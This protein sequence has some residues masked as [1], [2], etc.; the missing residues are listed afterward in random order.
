[1][2]VK[3][4][5]EMLGDMPEDMEVMFTYDYGD[6]WGNVV[7]VGF[8]SIEMKDVAWSDYHRMY[9]PREN[10]PHEEMDDT[11][12]PNKEVVILGSDD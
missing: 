6:H 3:E 10:A 12:H 11:R 9:Q 8:D 4:L 2:N 5:I 7:A 1:M